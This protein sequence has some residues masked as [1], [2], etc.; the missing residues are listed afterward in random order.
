MP[1]PGLRVTAICDRVA[2]EKSPD[3]IKLFTWRH[4]SEKEAISSRRVRL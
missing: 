1:L 3:M 2:R 4:R